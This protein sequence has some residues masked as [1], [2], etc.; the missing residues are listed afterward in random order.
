M[1]DAE[2][3]VVVARYCDRCAIRQHLPARPKKVLYL[4]TRPSDE[5]LQT[6]ERGFHLG[7]RAPRQPPIFPRSA[8][9]VCCANR[10]HLRLAV[11]EWRLIE[12]GFSFR[13]LDAEVND[14]DILGSPDYT[15]AVRIGEEHIRICFAVW[16]DRLVN[17]RLAV[18]PST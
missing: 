11:R 5:S 7:T 2:R 18:F 4:A 8:L 12:S 10:L 17:Q 14:P 9:F 6:C 13:A 15:D 3:G 16:I 1:E